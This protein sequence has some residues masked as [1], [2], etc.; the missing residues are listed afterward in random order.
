MDITV[1][2]HGVDS[3]SDNDPPMSAVS[4]LLKTDDG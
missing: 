3:A 2:K 1:G 4:D